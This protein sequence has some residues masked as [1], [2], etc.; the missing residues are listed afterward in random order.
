MKIEMK[1]NY[2]P[3]DT[4]EFIK[5]VE[6]NCVGC[7]ECAKFCTAGVWEADGAIYRPI[8]LKQCLE[9]GA[10]W[11]VCEYDAVIFGDPKGGTGIRFSYG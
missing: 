3:G 4:G 8:N 7:G 2:Y 11:N 1:F 6:D 10:C 5:V 9:C